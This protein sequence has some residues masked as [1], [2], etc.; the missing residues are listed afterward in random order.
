[1]ANMKLRLECVIP[2]SSV[3]LGVGIRERTTCG[4]TQ[5]TSMKCAILRARLT[6]YALPDVFR[7]H[8]G[9]R[10]RCHRK[11]ASDVKVVRQPAGKSIPTRTFPA[12]L[13]ELPPASRFSRLR[14]K[15]RLP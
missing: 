12:G 2:S 13:L 7:R 8:G 14:R 15:L 4:T 6:G 9:E 1:M 3:G 11:E 5:D 10:L